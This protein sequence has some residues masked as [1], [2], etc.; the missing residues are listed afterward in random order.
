M[1]KSHQDVVPIFIF[2]LLGI[3][4]LST[5]AVHKKPQEVQLYRFLAV[6]RW[7]ACRGFEVA[8][9]CMLTM[10]VIVSFNDL[11]NPKG[12]FQKSLPLIVQIIFNFYSMSYKCRA[13]LVLV[14]VHCKK[15]D[16]GKLQRSL[17]TLRPVYEQFLSGTNKSWMRI[18][19]DARFL[20]KTLLIVTVAIHFSYRLAA[21]RLAFGNTFFDFSR[22]FNSTY[23]YCVFQLCLKQTTVIPLRAV[24][25][26]IAFIF[27]QQ[28]LIYLIVL[29]VL[30]N[31]MLGSVKKDIQQ[32]I[33]DLAVGEDNRGSRSRQ[34][35][36]QSF[37]FESHHAD[38]RQPA[39]KMDLVRKKALK[40][41][42]LYITAK[43][44]LDDTT[45]VFGWILLVCV[46]CDVLT[47]L[48]HGAFLVIPQLDSNLGEAAL[49]AGA[50]VLFTSYAT[51]LFTPLFL[52]HEEVWLA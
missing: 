27:S 48:G 10:D 30:L 51:I 6:V 4:P 47:A 40:W 2:T 7:L 43:N 29:V 19:S 50:C 8:V 39:G 28:V 33:S 26:D 22:G 3:L 15:S 45:K 38:L 1:S 42:S 21:W 17:H 16:I 41:R 14:F 35:H 52:L 49:D 24:T 11:I 44:V 5:A 34:I 37:D 31:Q 13:V 20:S 9:L 36:A 18:V 23:D 12:E 46:G 25:L 32:V